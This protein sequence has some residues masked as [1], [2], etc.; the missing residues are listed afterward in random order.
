VVGIEED[1][2]LII[3]RM[4]ERIHDSVRTISVIMDIDVLRGD[5]SR[6]TINNDLEG[7]STNGFE[8]VG[9]GLGADVELEFIDEGV[10]IG[11]AL[12]DVDSVGG[13]GH[14]VVLECD[15]DCVF[16]CVCGRI[17]SSVS[18]IVVIHE[19]DW[20]ISVGSLHLHF[21]GISSLSH[22]ITIPV[23]G[24]DEERGGFG[25]ID[26]LETRSPTQRVRRVSSWFDHHVV[27]TL[28][29]VIVKQGVFCSQHAV[30]SVMSWVHWLVV[31]CVG[32]VLVVDHLGWHLILNW[33]EHLD[34]DGMA[35]MGDLIAFGVLG[36]DGEDARVS[37]VT[38]FKTRSI[39]IEL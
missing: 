14:S 6:G 24:F 26:I 29:D 28:F 4:G 15:I 34:V 8:G 9:L 33:I 21:E 10:S 2:E 36:N 11:G 3:A 12:F 31:H 23:S 16:S 22:I 1:I 13:L 7:F 39:H 20:D 5:G 17:F 25:V 19:R 27:G 32:S 37:S 30:D 35:T 18:S 38:T